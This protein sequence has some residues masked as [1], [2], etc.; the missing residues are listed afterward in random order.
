MQLRPLMDALEDPRAG[1]FFLAGI[2]VGMTGRPQFLT[3]HAASGLLSPEER[4]FLTEAVASHAPELTLKLHEHE[5][6][7]LHE[8]RSLEALAARFAHDMILADPT[9]SFSR[10]TAL[11]SVVNGLRATF[12]TAIGQILWEPRAARLL[13]VPVAEA[14]GVRETL[15]KDIESH[16]WQYRGDLLGGVIA[17]VE[18]GQPNPSRQYTPVDEKVHA[19]APWF[20]KPRRRFGLGVRLAALAALVGFGSM[21]AAD[22][23]Q[24]TKG[25]G[26]DG[27]LPGIAAFVDLTALGESA[28]GTRNLF[29]AA[30]GLRLYFG[31]TDAL[32]HASFQP[33][34]FG[35]VAVTPPVAVSSEP[36][37]PKERTTEESPVYIAYGA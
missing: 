34:G 16:V 20:E 6:V 27:H 23:L 10:L 15:Q 3:V 18:V 17:S 1:L 24:D 19:S 28:F 25:R 36:V 2:D 32:T 33:P 11:L 9:R 30:G 12:A 31:D 13:V 22:T 21:A 14:P 37:T 7:A 26:L 5:P 29:K 35:D 4:G 8:A